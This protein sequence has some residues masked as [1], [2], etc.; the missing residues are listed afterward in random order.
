[1]ERTPAEELEI[2]RISVAR[3]AQVLCVETKTLPVLGKPSYNELLELARKPR[4]WN[5]LCATICEEYER[6]D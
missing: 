1:M 2:L 4:G 6:Q 3:V 5:A